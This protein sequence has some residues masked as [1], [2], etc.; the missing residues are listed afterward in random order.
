MN[1]KDNIV[2]VLNIPNILTL[3]RIIII[4]VFITTVIYCRY[5]ISLILFIV[6]ALTDLLDGLIARL[7]NQKT[8][9]GTFLDPLADKFLLVSSFVILSIYNFIPEWLTVVVISRDIIIVVGWFILYLITGT[10]KIEPS[11][12]GKLTIWVQSFFIAYVLLN[13]NIS[14]LAYLKDILVY[15]TTVITTISGLEY[16]LKKGLKATYEK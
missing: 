4:P 10:P 2:S 16:I 1:N 6:A 8:L 12:L 3:I 13:I 15:L 9:I 5:N 14:F 7:T 11:V